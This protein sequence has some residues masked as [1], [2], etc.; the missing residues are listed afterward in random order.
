V[1]RFEINIG[2]GYG[3]V[4]SELAINGNIFMEVKDLTGAVS[5]V[6]SGAISEI[7][8]CILLWIIIMCVEVTY[9]P[10]LSNF[11]SRYLLLC[12]S[13]QYLSCLS[14]QLTCQKTTPL[15]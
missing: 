15:K 10:L 8:C 3:P 9:V 14:L 13:F 1:K 5:C 7:F 4:S 2:K 6:H 12:S 11:K